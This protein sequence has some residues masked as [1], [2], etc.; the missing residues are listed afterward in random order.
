MPGQRYAA[1]AGVVSAVTQNG[2][3]TPGGI[4][5]P[6]TQVRSLVLYPLS[7]GRM[8]GLVPLGLPVWS[9]ADHKLGRKQLNNRGFSLT[10]STSLRAGS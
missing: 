1:V 2:S 10:R 6:D 7:Y 9:G 5:T 8:S 3:G 4:R